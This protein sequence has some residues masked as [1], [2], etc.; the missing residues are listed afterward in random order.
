[1]MPVDKITAQPHEV[2]IHKRRQA[3]R[4]RQMGDLAVA[5]RTMPATPGRII[6]T[7]VVRQTLPQA[8][9]GGE[10]V[11]HGVNPRDLRHL[12]LLEACV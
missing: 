6:I 11:E 8:V 10:Q 12:M 4:R 3:R 9:V 7:K 1:M 2:F 5:Y